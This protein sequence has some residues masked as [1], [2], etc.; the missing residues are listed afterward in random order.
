MKCRQRGRSRTA[1]K[2]LQCFK[3]KEVTEYSQMG[4]GEM[5]ETTIGF[6]NLEVVSDFRE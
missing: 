6:C 1:A 4:I 2:E 3:K 5:W